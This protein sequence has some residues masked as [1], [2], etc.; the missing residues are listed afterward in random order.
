MR[1]SEKIELAKGK[2]GITSAVSMEE[3]EVELSVTDG[4]EWDIS[5]DRGPPKV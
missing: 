1:I 5:Y 2:E 4:E 3:D